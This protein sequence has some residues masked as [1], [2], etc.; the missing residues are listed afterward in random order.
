VSVILDIA[1]DGKRLKMLSSARDYDLVK[2][3]PGMRY[4]GRRKVFHAPLSFAVCV[5]ARGVFGDRLMVGDTLA[6][7]AWQVAEAQ[8]NVGL[9][10]SGHM[11]LP[12]VASQS[13]LYD[14]QQIGASFLAYVR[15]ALLGDEMG[16]G[17]TIQLI[18]A[19]KALHDMGINPFPLLIIGTNSMKHK[20]AAEFNTFYPEA[21]TSVVGG[22]GKRKAASLAPG[23]DVYVTNW[24]AAWRMSR[25][26]PYGSTRLSDKE[27]E[28]KELNAIGFRTVVADEAHRG[29]DPKSKQTRGWWYLSHAAENRY[30]L[31]GTAIA[32]SPVDAWSIMHALAPHD[33]PSRSAFIDRYALAGLNFFGG[34]EV[35][36][37]E[38]STREEFFRIFDPRF[39]ARTKA[40]VLPQLPAKTYS[41]R[42][43][44]LTTSQA[45]AYKQMSDHLITQLDTGLLMA[46]DPLVKMQRLLQIAAAT[47]V[48][49]EQ[50][51]ENPE[52][53]EIETYIAVV[54][55]DNPS[56]KIDALMDV[57]DEA[58][59][60]SVVVF[61]SSR[62]LI[63]LAALTLAKKKVSHV[64]ISGAVEPAMRQWAVQQFQDGEAQVALVT[65]GAGSEGITLTRANRAVFL[66]RSWSMVQNRQAE[67]RIHRIG[68]EADKVEI[69][70]IISKGT[71]DGAVI[72]VSATKEEM[73]QEIV[74]D[75]T[76]IK[77]AIEGVD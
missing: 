45:K 15:R 2:A 1:E 67:D 66:Q 24:E 42:P 43:V 23:F 22:T 70:D 48:L 72:G 75:P 74:R 31:T 37:L 27:R 7:W 35:Y 69:I 60:Q 76:W 29:K 41:V 13:H 11:T 36:G 39:L 14:F 53:G 47:P 25:L 18:A 52:T 64:V 38:P 26:A 68:Q 8:T 63:E 32:S 21:T 10:K 6:A 55:L 46:G 16:T 17:K 65:L 54:A 73:L 33:W 61:A 30:A 58:P 34:L 56:N 19:T 62:K 4:D 49:E 9:I 44:D 51:R 77:R 3:I 20:W 12:A 59:G 40:M 71:I 57:L 50:E 5:A 28:E